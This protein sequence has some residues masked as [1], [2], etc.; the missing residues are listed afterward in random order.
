MPA[1]DNILFIIRE[2]VSRQPGRASRTQQLG[3]V[4]AKR[5][6]GCAVH[7]YAAGDLYTNDHLFTPLPATAQW[8]DGALGM[9][10][11]HGHVHQDALQALD[12]VYLWN[13]GAAGMVSPPAPSNPTPLTP[14]HARYSK[15][16]F[17]AV[18]GKGAWLET[19][20]RRLYGEK[21]AR[22]MAKF[23]ALMSRHGY[24]PT[25]IIWFPFTRRQWNGENLFDKKYARE[26]R[27]RLAVNIRAAD[28]VNE[29]LR[30][31]DDA[32]G[33]Q[34]LEWLLTCLTVATRM[35]EMLTKYNGA[36]S[37]APAT[38]KRNFLK[39]HRRLTELVGRASHFDF[40]DPLGGDVGAWKPAVKML[41]E[42][43]T[44]MKEKS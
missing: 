2:Q 35:L 6:H 23:N 27:E 30:H 7:C 1:G 31:V 40:T 11:A 12:A 36:T 15:A 26:W 21:A 3:R 4:L 9:G 42:S 41:R 13:A 44:G 8:F 25:A 24:G 18:F 43:F 29:A 28:C 37:Q 16:Q 32:H 20:C 34:D 38:I 17:K 39:D 5:G 22:P 19:I 33:R 10:F 14:F